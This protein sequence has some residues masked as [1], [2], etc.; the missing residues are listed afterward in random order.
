LGVYG[1]LGAAQT[2][3]LLIL[4]IL[5]AITTLN[6]SK[7]M[8]KNMLVSVLHCPMSFY[9]TTPLGRIVNRFAKDVDICDNTLPMN[10]QQWLNTAFSFLGTIVLIVV[11]I[12]IFC[13]VIVPIGIIFILVQKVFVDTSR[14]LKRLE[15]ISR[16]PI[17]SHFG[18]TIAGMYTS[19]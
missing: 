4:S 14:Q 15:S 3:A 9:D 19:R 6:A 12:P 17:Y 2:I 13:A 11:I 8:H 5:I 7:R 10:I 1:G 18:E 16:S